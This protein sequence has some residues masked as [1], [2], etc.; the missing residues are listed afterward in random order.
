[1]VFGEV[2]IYVMHS[3]EY[4]N[5]PPMPSRSESAYF[6]LAFKPNVELVAVVRR[7]VSQFYD[8]TAPDAETVSRIALATQNDAGLVET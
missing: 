3:A 4:E 2:G 7:F 6:E 5:G 8:R 1:M